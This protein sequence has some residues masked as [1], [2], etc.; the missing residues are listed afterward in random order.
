MDKDVETFVKCFHPCQV[1]SQPTPPTEYL[2]LDVCG[3]F[4]TGD[5]ALVL[6]DYYSQRVK[7]EI[8]ITTTSAKILKWLESV[9]ATHGYPITLQTDCP[10]LCDIAYVYPCF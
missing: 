3:P 7:V 5:Y 10:K 4:P 6:I 9:F 8:V 1:T 2:A